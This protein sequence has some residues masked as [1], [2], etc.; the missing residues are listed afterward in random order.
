M[1]IVVSMDK[2]KL[3]NTQIR[4]FAEAND[5][6][7]DVFINLRTKEIIELPNILNGPT[8]EFMEFHTE[9]LEKVEAH[10]HE[11]EKIECPDSKESFEIM[12]SF[13]DELPEQNLKFTLAKALNQKRPFSKFN[14]IIHNCELRED[15]FK[16]KSDMLEQRVIRIVK[17]IN[18][19]SP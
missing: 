12:A 11:I 6:G 5:I 17:E 19:I 18:T 8:M 13:V 15:W 3:T 16:H 7:N 10:W 4:E 2:L 1:Y 14:Q 9:D